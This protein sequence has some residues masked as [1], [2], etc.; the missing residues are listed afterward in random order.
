[1]RWH[2]RR[3]RYLRRR[4]RERAR[5]RRYCCRARLCRR[6]CP[7]FHALLCRLQF[8]EILR[9]LF[10][11]GDELRLLSGELIQLLL[12]GGKLFLLG[13]ELLNTTP[14]SG[15]VLR[16]C[17]ELLPQFGR[18]F[19]RCGLCNWGRLGRG[20]V[21]RRLLSGRSGSL[22]CRGEIRLVCRFC[23]C[24]KIGLPRNSS[25]EQRSEANAS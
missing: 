18:W 21:C 7:R 15:H 10:L 8:R 14:H 1:M 12:G 24:D 11:L 17:L 16:H 13:G 23:R 19:R 22:F 4:L 5:R 3:W 20:R 2:A 6:R 9:H 25:A